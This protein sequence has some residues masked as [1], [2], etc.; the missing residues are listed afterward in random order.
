MGGMGM[1]FT[2]ALVSCLLGPLG[3]SGPTHMTSTSWTPSYSKQ[4]YWKL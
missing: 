2:P 1:I 4:S 3:L